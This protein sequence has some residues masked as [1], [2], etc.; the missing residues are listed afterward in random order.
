MSQMFPLPQNKLLSLITKHSSFTWRSFPRPHYDPVSLIVT[1]SHPL[2]HLYPHQP[3]PLSFTHL[4]VY[5]HLHHVPT[6]PT[7]HSPITVSTH[8]SILQPTIHL[9]YPL[10]YHSSTFWS[11]IRSLIP[12]ILLPTHVPR[13]PSTNLLT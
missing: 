3:L 10:P 1:Y 5:P 13:P 12:P 9:L 11:N 7:I 6:P 2:A 8:L 4:F